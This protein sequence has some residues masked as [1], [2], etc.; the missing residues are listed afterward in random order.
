M[1]TRMHDSLADFAA[2]SGELF[3]C[4]GNQPVVMDDAQFVWFLE[5]GVVDLFLV[6]RRDGEEISAPQ[7]LLRVEAG[8]LVPGFEA[9]FGDTT[10]EVIAKGTP[11]TVL[12]KLPAESLSALDTHETA[13]HVD[14]W[15]IEISDRLARD[16]QH[17]PRESINTRPGSIRTEQNQILSARHDP[18]WILNLPQGAGLFMGLIDAAER[19][20]QGVLPLT[21]SSWITMATETKLTAC[22]SETLAREGRLFPAIRSFHRTSL[23]LEQLNRRLALVDQ[24]N[25]EIAKTTNR[26]AE[27]DDAWDRLADICRLSQKDGFGTGESVLLDALQVIGHREN[28][29]F[30][31][32]GDTNAS[33]TDIMLEDILDASGVRGR[34]VWLNPDKEWWIGD[35]GAMLGFRSEDGQ[36]VA[37]LPGLWGRYREVDPVTRET[38]RLTAERAGALRAKAW[39]FYPPLPPKGVQPRDVLRLFPGRLAASCLQIAISGLLSC[40]IMLLPAVILGLV[41]EETIPAGDTG[42]LSGATGTLAVL[43][44]LSVLLYSLQGTAQ[45]RIGGGI[46]SRI[47]AAFWD[48]VLRLPFRLLNRHTVG[49][50]TMGSMAF[51]SLRDA[52]QGLAAS[53]ALSVFLLLPFMFLV[54]FYAPG[55]GVPVLFFALFSLFATVALG[56]WQIVP[57]GETTRISQNLTG[58]VHEIMDGIF[59]L[60]AEGAEGSAFAI[61]ARDYRKQK[62]VELKLGRREAW[63]QAFSNALPLFSTAFLFMAAMLSGETGV[64]KFLVVYIAFMTYQT[65]VMQLGASFGEIAAIASELKSVWPLVTEPLEEETRGES[66]SE[67]KGEVLFDHITF[68]YDADGPLIL[69]DVSIHVRPGEFVAIVGES[70]SGKSTLFRLALGEA[71]PYSGAV[72]YDGRD[73]KHLNRKQVR[74]QMGVVPQDVDLHPDDIWDNIVG[75]HKSVREDEMWSAAELA[76]V[77]RD[78]QRMPMKTATAV[79]VGN[80][81]LS[82]GE[83]QRIMIARALLRKPRIL[84]LDEA[85]NWLDNSRQAQIMANLSELNTTRIVIAHRLSTL[86]EVDRIYVLSGGKVAQTGTFSELSKV[87][88]TF[89]N[90]IRRQI[91]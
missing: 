47:E 53:S 25:L 54:G 78:V 4:A 87:E 91:A 2:E 90:L 82:G 32:P 71:E 42:L 11:G 51:S 26:R 50:I 58:K 23:Q 1:A 59:K 61:W 45:M 3:H 28:I 66:L 79:G 49:G 16:I 89:R 41:V 24:A 37:L 13:K 29:V 44:L 86:R 76:S 60:R 81:V 15:L 21:S 40:V 39:S 6:E 7:H 62:Y 70:G 9:Q 77:K 14:V 48:R 67:L 64:G 10:L 52:I 18:V 63:L 30:Q 31:K 33:S 84:L 72:Y 69:D 34:Q 57:R 68:R 74:R 38:T 12:R 73:L 35:S 75:H 88:G 55:L 83:A 17:R 20:M 80:Q 22:S 27:E 5:K 65:A 19:E 85:T 43:G 36:P 8:R 56:L 46:A